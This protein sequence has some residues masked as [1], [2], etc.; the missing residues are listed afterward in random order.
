MGGTPSLDSSRPA[1]DE[2]RR[3]TLRNLG[4]RRVVIDFVDEPVGACANPQA[5]KPAAMA[6]AKVDLT[7][8]AMMGSG[9]VDPVVDGGQRGDRQRC[10]GDE[11][12]REEERPQACAGEVALTVQVQMFG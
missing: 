9:P 11:S 3:A 2:G 6:A 4:A 12:R 10:A 8:V 5:T 1:G 7:V